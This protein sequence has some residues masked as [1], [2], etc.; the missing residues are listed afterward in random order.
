MNGDIITAGVDIGS[1][2]SK[3]LVMINGTALAY[4]I[5]PSSAN[6]A[7]TA[8]EVFRE[9][10]RKAGINEKDVAYVVGTGYGRANVAFANENV[11][12]ISCHAAGA[13]SVMPEVRTIIDIGGQDCKAISLENDG[14]LKNFAMNDKCAA[15]T[16]R[17]FEA[18]SRVFRMDL[19]EFSRLSL[20]ARKTIPVTAQCSVFAESEVISLLAKKQPPSD[21]AAGIQAAVA[22]RC[23]TLLKRIG[24]R[25]KLT[26]TGGC[27]K[28]AGL[29]KALGELLRMEIAPLV[30]DPQLMGALGAA[31]LACRRG[32][33]MDSVTLR[34]GDRTAAV[35]R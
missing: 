29:M 21:V 31:V 6:P 19:D 10:C 17:F 4:V 7:R 26:V 24:I 2:A 12:E 13:Y 35:P 1:T 33:K 5:G 27:A 22:K 30:V 28:N 8:S 3:A 16:G 9:S 25:E 34:V 15:G 14:R 23:F 20:N 32:G 18:M 11:S